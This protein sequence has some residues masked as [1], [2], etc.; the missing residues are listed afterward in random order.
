M[1][2]LNSLSTF[3]L[4]FQLNIGAG[5]EVIWDISLLLSPE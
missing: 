5:A 4:Q 3:L 2:T 1:I